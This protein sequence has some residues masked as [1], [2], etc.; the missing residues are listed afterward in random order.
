[1]ILEVVILLRLPVLLLSVACPG[2]AQAR[3]AFQP[4][5]I[6]STRTE[7]HETL[8]R[9][10][11][12]HDVYFAARRLGDET[13][14]PLLLARLRLD[15][16][17]SEPI[18]PPGRIYAVICPHAHLIDALRSITNTDHGYYYPRWKTWWETNRQLPRRQ[19][20]R[21]GFAAIGLHP[22]EPLD[23]QFALELIGILPD[24][25]SYL[26]DNARRLLASAKPDQRAKWVARAAASDQPTHRLGALYVLDRIDTAGCEEIIHKLRDDPDQEV[27]TLAARILHERRN[28]NQP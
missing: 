10:G 7:L 2:L 4:L 13:T 26:G 28:A 21:D 18:P 25:R 9:G 3:A 20:V 17:A 16:G 11:S 24:R 5:G 6:P 8:R 1:M 27:R 23:D 12:L 22:A 14:V 19:W 15:Y